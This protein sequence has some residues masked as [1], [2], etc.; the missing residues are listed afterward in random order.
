MNNIMTIKEFSRS[1][2]FVAGKNCDEAVQGAAYEIYK[3]V[4]SRAQFSDFLSIVHGLL[5][6][7]LQRTPLSSLSQRG[8]VDFVEFAL[9]I[10]CK[11]TLCEAPKTLEGRAKI[12][13]MLRQLAKLGQF[14]IL[15]KILLK[16]G[17][18]DPQL[19]IRCTAGSRKM[20]S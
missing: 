20:P 13:E 10:K 8:I 12:M 5:S 4:V 11:Y 1:C 14:V 3:L 19:V 16:E 18:E 17:E 15:E 9:I 2:G 6:V 7:E